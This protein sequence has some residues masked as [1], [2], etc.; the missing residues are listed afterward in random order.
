MADV[1]K[2]I[3]ELFPPGSVKGQTTSDAA[4]INGAWRSCQATTAQTQV[5]TLVVFVI[6]QYQA[7]QLIGGISPGTA[8]KVSTLIN[9]LYTG[10]GLA[11]PN[12]PIGSLGAGGDVGSGLFIPGTETLIKTPSGNAA[13][14]V[15]ANGF[16]EPTLI[17]IIQLPDNLNPLNTTLNQFPPFYDINASNASNSH[18]LANGQAIV[19]FCVEDAVLAQTFDPQIGHNPVSGAPGFPFE[20]L[21]P[22]SAEEYASL[23]LNCPVQGNGGGG[24]SVGSLDRHESL[25]SMAVRAWNAAKQYARRAAEAVLPEPLHA[26][27]MIAGTGLGGRTSSFSPFGVVDAASGE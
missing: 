4:H 15:P 1:V 9:T 12:L 16:N 26:A 8:A 22:A 18:V 27:T 20:I 13:A 7:A 21:D 10:V 6:Q 25:G 19:G 24:T 2:Q 5:G 23:E 14:L 17:T 11:A 3:K